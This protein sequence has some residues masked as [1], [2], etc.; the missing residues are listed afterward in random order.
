MSKLPFGGH[1]PREKTIDDDAD[2]GP[3][4]AEIS[5]CALEGRPLR[6]QLAR[7]IHRK[8]ERGLVKVKRLRG[9]DR[10]DSFDKEYA[11]L[12]AI[13]E[14]TEAGIALEKAI[15]AVQEQLKLKSSRETIHRWRR[16]RL[17]QEAQAREERQDQLFEDARVQLRALGSNGVTGAAAIARVLDSGEI[18]MFLSRA[19]VEG[20]E[21]EVAKEIASKLPS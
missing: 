7:W 11:A 13:E 18:P 20:L 12:Q 5:A 10:K 21:S 3:L 4:L 8:I 17:E 14:L 16:E 19:V 6:P 2:P 9:R 15:V 1:D